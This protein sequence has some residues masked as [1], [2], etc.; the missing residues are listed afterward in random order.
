MGA[1]VKVGII[2]CGNI[3][4]QYIRGCRAFE[5]L[6]VVACADADLSRAQA[7]AEEFGGGLRACSVDELLNDPEIEIVVNLTIPSAH[8]EIS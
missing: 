6:D 1:A 2:G 4:P 5:I 7:R 8:A 3:F